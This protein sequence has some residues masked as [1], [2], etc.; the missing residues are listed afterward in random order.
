MPPKQGRSVS[1]PSTPGTT[2]GAAARTAFKQRTPSQTLSRKKSWV[3]ATEHDLTAL[4]LSPLQQRLRKENALKYTAFVRGVRSPG[5][6]ETEATNGG[7]LGR[8]SPS[9]SQMLK[10]V[11]ENIHRPVAISKLATRPLS[12]TSK[13]QWGVDAPLED[14]VDFDAELDTWERTNRA[15]RLHTRRPPLG[16]LNIPADERP[17]SRPKE[18]KL[19][20]KARK[21]QA[22]T[23][24]PPAV[25]PSEERFGL[26][27]GVMHLTNALAS[28]LDEPFRRRCIEDLPDEGDIS[29]EHYTALLRDLTSRATKF[30]CKNRLHRDDQEEWNRAAQQRITALEDRVA[31]LELA[32]DTTQSEAS[33][34][35]QRWNTERKETK[36]RFT[37]LE[38]QLKALLKL[39]EDRTVQQLVALSLHGRSFPPLESESTDNETMA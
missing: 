12:P 22:D 11:N 34:L 25:I 37:A 1:A 13:L 28:Q 33:D 20:S 16:E 9:H 17:A 35:R 15:I 14:I 29:V 36:D 30:V 21:A 38:T 7:P 27:V 26:A 23:P 18:H 5:R 31:V 8:A 3:D 6:E 2:V 32:L 39:E 19:A 24:P 4:K 10:G